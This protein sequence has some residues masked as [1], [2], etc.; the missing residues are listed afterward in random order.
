MQKEQNRREFLVRLAT[1]A[2]G[3]VLVPHVVS[4]GSSAPKPDPTVTETEV[5]ESELAEEVDEAVEETLDTA[6]PQTEPTGWDPINYNRAR[7]NAG[8]IP[9]S[10]LDDINGPE[11]ED[12]HLGKHLPYIPELDPKIVPAGYIA[13]MWGDPDKGHAKHPNAPRTEDNPEGHWYDWIKVRKAVEGEAEELQ[14]SYSDWPGTT[15]SDN[16]A[17]AVHGGGDITEE[18]GKNTV[19]LCAIPGD[20]RPGDTVRIWAHC[21]TH[22]E[23]VDF[24]KV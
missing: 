15:E 17:Y 4:C 23:Y 6:V 14:S 21:L 20:V 3:V 2:G 19:Y 1:V 16:G 5:D 12:Q 11:G 9:D 18:S 10:Y 22:G 7:G 8:A 24:I 13:L